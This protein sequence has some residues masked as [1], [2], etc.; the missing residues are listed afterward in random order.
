MDLLSHQRDWEK[1]IILAYKSNY[2]QR[3]NQ[4]IFLM[5][6]DNETNDCYY[7][8]VKSLSEINSLG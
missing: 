4:V 3:K 2:H 8:A 1:L 6:N 7:F 5:I